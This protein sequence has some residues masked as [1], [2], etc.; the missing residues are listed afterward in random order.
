MKP[1]AN[2]LI[3]GGVRNIGGAL[4]PKLA[5]NQNNYVVIIDDLSAGSLFKLPSLNY[6][7]WQLNN[8]HHEKDSQKQEKGNQIAL[9]IFIRTYF[10]NYTLLLSLING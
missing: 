7:N 9:V 10:H 1:N 2:I 8:Y 4:A 5:S 6:N 3:T